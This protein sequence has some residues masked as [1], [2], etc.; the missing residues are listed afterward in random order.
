MKNFTP[1]SPILLLY[2]TLGDT[3]QLVKGETIWCACGKQ[4]D[5]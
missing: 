4:I 2:A 3:R 1:L 5:K